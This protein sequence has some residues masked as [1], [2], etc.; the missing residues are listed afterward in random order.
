ML[1]SLKIS[2]LAKKTARSLGVAFLASVNVTF[3][4]ANEN[5]NPDLSGLD[6]IT[7]VGVKQKG[8]IP[9]AVTYIAPELLEIQNYTDINRV[10][11]DVPG[12]NLQEEDGFGLRP[13]IGMRGS[14][15]DR[16]SKLLILEDGI[17][18]SPAPFSAPSAYYFPRVARMHAV[19]VTKGTG[20]VKYGPITTAGAIQFFSTPIPEETAARVTALTSD[21][22]R[23]SLHAWAGGRLKSDNLPVEIGVLL[24]TY[25]DKADGFKQIDIGKTGFSL[26]DYVGKLGFYSKDNAR[27]DQQLILKYQSSNETADETYLGLTATDFESRPF[28]RYAASQIDQMNADHKTYQATHNIKFSDTLQL[29]T[30]AYRT[31]F[32]RNWEKLDRFNNSALSGSPSCDSL[33]EILVAPTLCQQELQ[34]LTGPQGYTSP[35]D[36]LGIRQNNRSYYAQGIQTALGVKFDTGDIAHN[37]VVS[38]R[39]HEDA[40]DRFQEQDQ[41]RIENGLVVKTTDNAPGTQSNRLSNSQSLAVYA[42]DAVS[43]GP[44]NVTVG[45]RYED[46][47]SQQLRWSSPDRNIAPTSIRE[48]TNNVFIPSFGVVYDMSDQF[49]VLAGVYRG[50]AL[51]SVSARTAENEVSTSYET[52]GRYDNGIFQFEA[53]GFF[54]DYQNLV[55]E[56]TNSSG[57]SECD[58]GDSDNA[59]AA[60]V[61][62]LEFTAKTDLARNMDNLSLPVNLVYSY[63]DTELL[64]TVSSDIYG[65][66][67]A[68]DTIPY[69]PT[70]QLTLNTGFIKDK[71]G[72]NAALN[73][74]SDVR[75]LPGQ[76]AIPNDQLVEARTLVDIAAYYD[77]KDGI[78]L[79]LKA[80][81]VFDTVYMAGRRPYGIRPGKPREIFAGISLDF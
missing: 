67:T 44:W 40:V 51:P 66:V 15:T 68:G 13:N 35:D 78:R 21:L 60:H 43:I 18:M 72:I 77:L 14:G 41:Y 45:L 6:I 7:V 33:N 37:L 8:Q 29:T 38:A 59:G 42:E 56:C 10:L 25:Q 79:H 71:W 58:I 46:V 28:F 49:S 31:E 52:G 57:G 47:K 55:A 5:E 48:N 23:T 65:N 76:G 22:G 69:V 26:A 30:L 1:N 62:G 12:I 9:G 74:V 75:N 36:V 19:E 20:A 73:Y 2:A 81:N 34:V 27:F 63:T 24:E 32:A 53:I 61:Y 50:F 80:D 4:S 3:A 17:P 39:Y 54:N 11:R 70:H 16:S 64:N